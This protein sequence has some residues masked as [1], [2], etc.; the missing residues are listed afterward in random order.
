MRGWF[1]LVFV[2]VWVSGCVGLA[3]RARPVLVERGCEAEGRAALRVMTLNVAHGRGDRFHQSQLER[4]DHEA[5]LGEIAAVI[6]R[7]APDVVALQES[8]GPSSWS[9]GF[10]HVAWLVARS[11]WVCS[12]VRGAHVAHE[13]LGERLEYGTAVLSRGPVRRACSEPFGLSWVDTKGFVVATVAAP[14]WGEEAAVDVVSVHL[15]FLSELVRRRQVRRL[16]AALER[17]RR[18]VVVMGDFN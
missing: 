9:G 1:V 18:P 4:A 6:D 10:D 11:A 17:R 13:V 3:P 14:G 16:V 7:E 5:I 15:D 12:G 8:D 2:G